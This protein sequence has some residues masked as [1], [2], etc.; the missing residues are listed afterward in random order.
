MR[1]EPGPTGNNAL[2]SR[3]C[4]ARSK[5]PLVVPP[6]L[7]RR[8]SPVGD[9][10]RKAGSPTAVSEPHGAASA[11]RSVRTYKV[12]PGDSFYSIAKKMYGQPGRWK[13]VYAANRALVKNDP[14]RL[15]P[16]M[17]LRIPQ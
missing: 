4:T 14:K 9:P 3:A 13:D 12:Q 16:G 11:T 1:Q 2:E 10:A 8:R 6:R 7:C 17:M 15:R 5:T